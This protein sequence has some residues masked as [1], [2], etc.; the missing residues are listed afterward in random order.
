VSDLDVTFNIP[1][2]YVSL[3]GAQNRASEASFKISPGICEVVE[4]YF[5]RLDGAPF[6]LTPYS[7]KFIVWKTLDL[8]TKSSTEDLKNVA[9]AKT[10]LIDD[11]YCQTVRTLLTSDDTSQIGRY[12]SR[13]LRWSLFLIDEDQ[14]VFPLLVNKSGGTFGSVMIDAIPI[15]DI[16]LGN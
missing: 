15:G 7:V 16:V 14:N 2:I 4:F 12:G 9:F 5:E 10:L 3:P 8:D 6:N 1:R 13:K 11:P